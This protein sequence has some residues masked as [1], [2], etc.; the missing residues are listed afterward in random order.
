MPVRVEREDLV[1]WVVFDRPEKGNALGMEELEEARRAVEAECSSGDH[2][3]VALTGSGD[4]F[5]TTGV[6]L[7]E[8]VEARDAEAAWRLMYEGLGGLCRAIQGCRKPVVAAVNGYALGAGMEL[9]YFVDLAYAVRSAKFGVPPV[10][11]GMVPPATPTVGVVLLGPRAA[12]YLA[13]TG[14]MVTAEEALSMG[15]LNGVVDTVEELRAKV[16]EV[17]KAI[18]QNE[19]EAVAEVRRLIVESKM[20]ALSDKGLRTLAAFTARSVVAER[21]RALFK[22]R[23]SRG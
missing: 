7:D 17:A 20:A 6:D 4:R 13:L 10:R 14:E 21:I 3:V 18:A 8:I 2:A 9:L 12:A 5:F 16:R 11:Y 23:P 19:P 22:S 1:S 15:F